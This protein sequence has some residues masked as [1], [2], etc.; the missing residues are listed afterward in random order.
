M[1]GTCIPSLILTN[2]SELKCFCFVVFMLFM[3]C[4]NFYNKTC[5][6]INLFDQVFLGLSSKEQARLDFKP[7]GLNGPVHF[8]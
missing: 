4:Y 2:R 8:R 3:H 6:S 5:V 1:Y 7:V